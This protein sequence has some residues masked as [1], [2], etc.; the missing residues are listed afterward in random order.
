[1]SEEVQAPKPL[2]LWLFVGLVMVGCVILATGGP[3]GILPLVAGVVG[4]VRR[5]IQTQRAS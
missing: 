3:L 1:V 4:L 5:F 2:P